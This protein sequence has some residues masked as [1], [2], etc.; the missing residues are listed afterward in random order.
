MPTHTYS[1]S[2]L[3]TFRN[4]PRQFKIQYVDKIAAETESVEAFMGGR[5]HEV[6]E[7]LY[8]DVQM[9]KLPTK[10]EVLAYFDTIWNEKWHDGVT[11]VKKDYTPENYRG[12]GRKCVSE[13]YDMHHP[14]DATRTIAL[15][16]LVFFPLDED[17]NYWV[18][19]FIDRVALTDDG[20]YEIHDY[21]TS[22]RLKTQ[23]Q[24]DK[25][26]QLALYQIAVQRDWRDAENVELVWHYLAFGKELRS[27]RSKDELETLKRE[28]MKLIRSVERESDFRPRES[29]LCD[30]CA[31]Q[32]Y[33]PAKK[34]V[35]LTGRLPRNEYLDEPGVRL[36]NKYAELDRK[37]AGLD[38]DLLKVKE[39]L[40]AYARKHEVEVVKGSDHRVLVRFY[41][42]LSFPKRDE[43]GRQELEDLV[44]ESGLWEKVS[45]MSPVSLAKL[46]ERGDLDGELA[47]KIAAM[48]KDE[49]R[50]WVKLSGPGR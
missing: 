41:R 39:A 16:H 49:V 29:A 24:I 7:K 25:D 10:D 9:T 8:K 2:R 44:R 32:K 1:H 21:K 45:V 15:E 40:I 5:V 20:K 26:E 43:P 46:V 17:G 22:G 36:V 13:Y 12:V 11:V 23:G 6:L 3:E 19:G 27:T 50:P 4:C 14:F 30:W 37:K 28:T 18:R 31:Y 47:R 34:H 38:L 35:L 48:G 33:C 42:G